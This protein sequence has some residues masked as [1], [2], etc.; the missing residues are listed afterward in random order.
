[1]SLLKSKKKSKE[2]SRS[3]FV[4]KDIKEG[5][6]LTEENIRSIRSGFG[7]KTKYIKDILGKTVKMDLKKGTPMDWKFIKEDKLI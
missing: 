6:L 1:M 2:H 4:V 3:L 7:M 5:E